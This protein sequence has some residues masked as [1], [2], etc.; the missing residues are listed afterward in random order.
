MSTIAPESPPADQGYGE[1]QRDDGR[2]RRRLLI[3]GAFGV[4]GLVLASVYAFGAATSTTQTDTANVED[5]FVAGAAGASTPS[6]YA[7][8]ITTPEP[9][10]VGFNG[11]WGYITNDTSM[12]AVDLTQWPAT[13][14]FYVS[15]YLSNN[16]TGWSGLQ[17]KLANRTATAAAPCNTT[18]DF[19]GA[20][21]TTVMNITS[22]DAEATFSGL[23]GGSVYCLGVADATP[24]AN[25]T[26]GTFLRRPTGTAV[27]V[28]PNFIA[29]VNRSA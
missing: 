9:L 21:S 20:G 4:L 24:Q 14:T 1:D 8:A 19:S 16:P 11:R 6:E 5:A 15:V 29:S 7:G 2:K 3:W 13:E 10:S 18:N 17:F 26:N 22:Q 28:M 12:F 27:P 25:D 23:A